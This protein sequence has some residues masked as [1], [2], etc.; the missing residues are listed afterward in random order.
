MGRTWGLPETLVWGMADPGDAVPSRS[1]AAQPERA[2]WLASLANRAAD[3]MLRSDPAELGEALGRLSN[4]F[5][6]ALELQAQELQDAAGRARRRLTELS[7]ALN[8][9]LP[10]ESPGERLLDTFYVDTP[11]VP[12]DEVWS[13]VGEAPTLAR[14]PE[15]VDL[16]PPLKTDAG[17][18]KAA[19]LTQGI[20]DITR[21]LLGSFQL[22]DVLHLILRTMLAALDCATRAPRRCRPGWRWA[23]APSHWCRSFV[24]RWWRP[25]RASPTCSAPC[26]SRT[27]TP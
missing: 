12:L 4:T 20:Q 15:A 2:W 5:Q 1:L 21:I 11:Q 17:Q 3:T 25:P 18:D 22:Q 27:S 19:L 8:F 13:D 6:R 16:A 9:Y 10:A 26:A 23:R 24:C 7:E 14:V